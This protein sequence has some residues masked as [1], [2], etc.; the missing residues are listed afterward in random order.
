MARWLGTKSINFV[1]HGSVPVDILERSED[2]NSY[3]FYIFNQTKL[4]NLV[5]SDRRPLPLK[6]RGRPRKSVEASEG[7]KNT[8]PAKLMDKTRN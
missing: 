2:G 4:Q 6:K 8:P 1:V 5:E 3:F 7:Q